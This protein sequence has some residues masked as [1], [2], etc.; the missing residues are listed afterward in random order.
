MQISSV[1]DPDPFHFR[2]PDP[3]FNET[4]PDPTP[5]LLKN[6][7]KVRENNILQKFDHFFTL[8]T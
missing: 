4:D 6:Q 5:A 7:P 2:L 3:D 8:N 1:V